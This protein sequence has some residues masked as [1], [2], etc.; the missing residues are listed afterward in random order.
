MQSLENGEI[1]HQ[2]TVGVTAANKP[3]NRFN[4]IT[5]CEFMLDDNEYIA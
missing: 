5:V 2:V 1:D 3:L 4:N